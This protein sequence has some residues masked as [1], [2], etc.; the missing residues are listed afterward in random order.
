[1]KSDIIEDRYYIE[2]PCCDPHHLLVFDI[3]PQFENTNWECTISHVD[4]HYDYNTIW[5]RIKW[6]F[7]FILNPNKFSLN[8]QFM[9]NEGN[10]DQFEKVVKIMREKLK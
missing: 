7:R 2:C 8:Q 10:V 6:A 4:N 1:M 9:I 5:Q 3:Y